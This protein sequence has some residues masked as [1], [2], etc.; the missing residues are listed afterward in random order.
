MSWWG[1]L[2]VILNFGYAAAIAT[3]GY[4]CALVD[5]AVKSKVG[6]SIELDCPIL[7]LRV[8]CMFFSQL[9]G[10]RRRASA[11]SAV[12]SLEH[13]E[14]V[15]PTNCNGLAFKLKTT[16]GKYWYWTWNPTN[17]LQSSFMANL[18]KFRYAFWADYYLA[19]L[20]TTRYYDPAHV[21]VWLW[22]R[23]TTKCKGTWSWR[24]CKNHWK[25]YFTEGPSP[26]YKCC[27]VEIPTSFTLYNWNPST[28]L[29]PSPKEGTRGWEY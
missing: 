15:F 19:Y 11:N 4:I 28:C 13:C 23:V 9:L 18:S 26:L 8:L 5:F 22:S 2:E 10:R 3:E 27:I 20:T 29:P 14:N 16:L 1:S 24:D 12:I 21:W 7:G 6:A 25:I 17:S